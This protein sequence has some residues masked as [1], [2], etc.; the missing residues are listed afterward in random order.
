MGEFHPSA[1]QILENLSIGTLS[2]LT[3]LSSER[4]FITELDAIEDVSS[5]TLCSL[6]KLKLGE[7]FRA[8]AS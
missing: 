4:N 8:L 1:D 5:A 7:D 2:P 3:K 6:L